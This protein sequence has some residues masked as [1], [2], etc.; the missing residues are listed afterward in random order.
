V[1][2]LRSDDEIIALSRERPEC[3]VELFERHFDA[4]CRYLTRHLGADLGA[5]L[6]AEVFTTAFAARGRYAGRTGSAEPWLYGIATNLLRRHRR[7]QSRQLAALAKRAH[8]EAWDEPFERSTSSRVAAALLDLTAAERE[9]LLL[10]AWADLSYAQVA[11]ALACPVGTVR[12]RL[13]RA[14]R[15]LRAALADVPELQEA[16]RE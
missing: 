11:E 16:R 5:D 1:G 12:S 14:R 10:V 9:V 13:H 4:I 3:F 2:P 15:T 8:D 7:R 6:A